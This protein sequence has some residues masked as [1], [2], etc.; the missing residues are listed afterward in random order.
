[1]SLLHMQIPCKHES[2]ANNLI[3]PNGPILKRT[4][5]LNEKYTQNDGKKF[6]SKKLETKQNQVLKLDACGKRQVA[7]GK[8]QVRIAASNSQLIIL[9]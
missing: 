7:S 3:I 1:M 4:G 6:Y 5:Y 8:W 2:W 9:F